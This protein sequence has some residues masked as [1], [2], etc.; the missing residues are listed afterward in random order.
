MIVRTS[1]LH[2]LGGDPPGSGATLSAAPAALNLTLI[3]PL[4][5]G[6]LN[7]FD[8]SGDHLFWDKYEYGRSEKREVNIYTG[9]LLTPALSTFA[10]F[11]HF[12]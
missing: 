1:H 5:C 10:L 4:C 12:T 8:Y 11:P 2:T 3:K 9:D 6:S 7:R